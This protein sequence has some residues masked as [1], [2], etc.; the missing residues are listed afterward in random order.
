MNNIA[1]MPAR[2]GSH[3]VEVKLASWEQPSNRYECRAV[4]CPE[5]EGGFSVFALNLPG[6]AS[7]GETEDEAICNIR[8]AFRGALLAY[9]ERN[10]TIPWADAAQM[11][12]EADELRGSKQRWIVVDV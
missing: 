3:F 5:A 8:E 10:E 1:E 12:A 9:C 4:F 2:R 6:V 7:Q 11:E